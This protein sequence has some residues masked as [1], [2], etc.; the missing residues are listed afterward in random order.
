MLEKNKIIKILAGAT[1]VFIVACL[2]N[3]TVQ[4]H[5]L[6]ELS[7]KIIPS[8][9]T[10]EFSDFK[11]N[12]LTSVTC[13]N[14]KVETQTDLLI[15][16]DFTFSWSALALLKGKIHIENLLAHGL[17]LVKTAQDPS[18]LPMTETLKQ[19]FPKA[20][21]LL[22]RLTIDQ[23]DLQKAAL[24]EQEV[25]CFL[26]THDTQMIS[27]KLAHENTT[28]LSFDLNEGKLLGCL[29]S[30]N[31]D[32]HLSTKPECSS[33]LVF[34]DMELKST[35]AGSTFSLKGDI[36]LEESCLNISCNHLLK[37]G[38]KLLGASNLTLD[39]DQIQ[40]TGTL[41]GTIEDQEIGLGITATPKD[42]LL[43][44]E[45]DKNPDILSKALLK[46]DLNNFSNML[47]SLEVENKKGALS[48]T[49]DLQIFESKITFKSLN[50]N[51]INQ[52]IFSWKDKENLVFIS[53]L[54]PLD[55]ISSFLG[56]PLK[57]FATVS[58]LI[59]SKKE[60]SIDISLKDI[61]DNQAEIESAA[62]KAV[63]DKDK[64][65]KNLT[66]QSSKG[67]VL[68]VPFQALEGN[69]DKTSQKWSLNI[70]TYLRNKV[71]PAIFEFEGLF[72]QNQLK[73]DHLKLK[74][75][76]LLVQNETPVTVSLTPNN[77]K[78]DAFSISVNEGK[79]LT[80]GVTFTPTLQG[81]L[82]A[83]NVPLKL[84]RTITPDLKYEGNF[85][86]E[87]FF[88][89]Q[90][91]TPDTLWRYQLFI[92]NTKYG[93]GSVQAKDLNF[94]QDTDT[95]QGL[96]L[97]I[98]G[99]ATKNKLTFEI[100]P[101]D[102]KD[103]TLSLKAALDLKTAALDGNLKIE[104]L[105]QT[106]HPLIPYGEI[107]GGHVKADI[108]LKGSLL[109]P[110]FQGDLSLQKGY[111]ELADYGTTLRD[112]NAQIE[113]RDKVL[114][115]KGLT[116]KDSRRDESCGSVVGSGSLTLDMKSLILFDLSLE[117]NKLLAVYSDFLVVEA[118]GP[119]SLKGKGLESLIKG[120]IAC[121][122]AQVDLGQTASGVKTIKL[123]EIVS[124]KRKNRHHKYLRQKKKKQYQGVIFPI[125]LLLTFP[126]GCQIEGLGINTLL[127]GSLRVIE[128]LGNPA[129]KGDLE[130]EKGGLKLF[131]TQLKIYKG[132]I[133][134][135]GS[136]KN[137]PTLDLKAGKKIG[138]YLVYLNIKGTSVL[139]KITFTANPA[140]SPQEAMARLVFGKSINKLSA[141]ESLFVATSLAG[142]GA[143]SG[144][145]IDS[146]KTGLGFD[147]IEIKESHDKE[148]QDKQKGQS[149]QLGKR[150]SDKVFVSLNQGLGSDTSKAS[151][152]IMI[153]DYVEGT[154]DA[155]AQT[156][157]AELKL[158]KR[159]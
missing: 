129:L 143:Q 19:I 121:S 103:F 86:L 114:K 64:D 98:K 20:L 55:D 30:Q 89:A 70:T 71:K 133:H 21:K 62:L 147:T 51:N 50:K 152:D 151:V 119:I 65:L 15:I 3:S 2:M 120:E 88:G 40:L 29:E 126:K 117:L 87:S 8:L 157:G 111:L 26:K 85:F 37:E 91:D 140:L 34:R 61:K 25:S 45:S 33:I 9:K 12:L 49:A 48:L 11:G 68:S 153:N 95:L 123:K 131:N 116:A 132:L 109:N 115:I 73:I 36:S 136:P 77:T 24:Y 31:G 125:D 148:Q 74:A 146:L 18:A 4:Q 83:Q 130:A 144:G 102:L 110:S 127:N 112:M 79:I 154:L 47:C 101:L 16:E 128:D 139:P 5:L 17:T 22:S 56:F 96:T 156:S 141:G 108:A 13:K 66:F 100:L 145:I 75:N 78:I 155:G 90:G 67:V 72:D 134:Y 158:Y 14:L 149:L 135:D 82:R 81:A 76:Y 38:K 28:L 53:S 107:I 94:A 43:L 138:N 59:S 35:L 32:I 69:Y 42:L 93:L 106:L 63:L 104:G 105:L 137:E 58:A 27:F 10:F 39:L 92:E 60:S 7:P 150:L 84:L 124:S 122:I 54:L 1:C 80:E 118:T 52:T 99:K 159:Y 97:G 46:V 41:Q 113:I 142:G 57:A 44:Y 23:L 6:K